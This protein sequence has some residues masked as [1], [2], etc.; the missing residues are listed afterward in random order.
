MDLNQLKTIVTQHAADLQNL[1]DDDAAAFLNNK[2]IPVPVVNFIQKRTL[3]SLLGVQKG[4]TL[5]NTLR[6][7]TDPVTKEIVSMLDD[8]GSG[9]IDISLAESQAFVDQFVAATLLSADDGA[10]IKALGKQNVS[11]LGQ[12][13]LPD[14]TAQDIER[15]RV[16]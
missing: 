7:S 9:G 2:N 16:Q 4:V 14:A 6:A 1:S 3:F 13:G 10:K 8:V 15:C 12:A 11:I 5:L